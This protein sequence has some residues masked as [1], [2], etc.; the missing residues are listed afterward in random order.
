MSSD[1]KY[2]PVPESQ[3][4]DEVTVRLRKRDEQLTRRLRRIRVVVRILDFGFGYF[5]L[6]ANLESPQLR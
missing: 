6:N 4:Y 1:A 2:N 5:W 3:P